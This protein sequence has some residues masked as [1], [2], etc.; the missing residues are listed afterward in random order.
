MM[1]QFSLTLT[2]V[3]SKP[4]HSAVLAVPQMPSTRIYLRIET[5]T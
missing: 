4:Q 1:F 5:A 3:Y 2:F